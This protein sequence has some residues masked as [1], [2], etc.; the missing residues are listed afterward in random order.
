MSWNRSDLVGRENSE[1]G[2]VRGANPVAGIGRWVWPAEHI[3]ARAKEV[4]EKRTFQVSENFPIRGRVK[5]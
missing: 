5:A 4:Q 3:I 1:I 2:F